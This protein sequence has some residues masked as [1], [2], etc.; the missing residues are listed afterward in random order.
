MTTSRRG[1]Y[2]D[3]QARATAFHVGDRVYP[4]LKGN[5]SNGGTV[6]AVWP[7][8]GMV[9]VQYPHGATRAPVEDLLIDSGSSIDASVDVAYDSVPGGTHTVPVSGGPPPPSKGVSAERV[10]GPLKS[11]IVDD[12]NDDVLMVWATTPQGAK[13]IA[14]RSFRRPSRNEWEPGPPYEASVDP[15]PVEFPAPSVQ[16]FEERPEVLKAVA[17]DPRLKKFRVG[18][19]SSRVATG[20]LNKMA[21]YWAARGRQYRPCKTEVETGK[22]T[23]PRCEDAYLRRVIYK[24]DEGQRVRLFCCP[25]CLFLVR[26]S[27]VLGMGDQ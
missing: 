21:V 1:S 13:G 25:E 4:I 15:F 16:G 20:H 14:A 22:L 5:P 24:H 7:A 12:G 6:V 10:A 19:M 27:D 23:C 26:Q 18:S 11:W 17:S 8:I 9:D 3:Y 2:V